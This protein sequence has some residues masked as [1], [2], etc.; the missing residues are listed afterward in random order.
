MLNVT[1]YSPDIT[2]ER[3]CMAAAALVT[4]FACL[5]DTKAACVELTN[6]QAMW[7]AVDHQGW[8]V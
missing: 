3:H 4:D 7:L 1:I 2:K 8:P 6:V 5:S